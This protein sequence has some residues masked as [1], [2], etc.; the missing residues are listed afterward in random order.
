[1]GKDGSIKRP[2]KY[3]SFN[4]TSFTHGKINLHLFRFSAFHIVE[5]QCNWTAM[6]FWGLIP[7]QVNLAFQFYS[8]GKPTKS[9]TYPQSSTT[10]L[11]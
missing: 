7:I 9:P 5:L 4:L 6:W 11:F 2:S 10:I 8:F 3:L 1:M